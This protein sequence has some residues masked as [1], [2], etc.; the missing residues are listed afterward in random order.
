MTTARP[1]VTVLLPVYNQAQ[2]IGACI[3]SLLA[4]TYTNFELL[5]INDGSTDGTVRVCQS[6]QD[7]RIRLITN[8]E[9]K[10]I[11]YT[12]NRG[13]KVA[14]AP[15]I[16]R[17][18]ADDLATPDRLAHQHSYM[19]KHPEIGGVASWI[20]K[21]DAAGNK[22]KD[23]SA[24]LNDDPTYVTWRLM[25]DNPIAHTTMM[26]PTELV[27]EIGGYSKKALHTE[28][29]ELW[30]RIHRIRPIH[31]LPEY[32]I[33]YRVHNQSLSH[34]YRPDQ[35]L[36][37]SQIAWQ[38]V[39][40]SLGREVDSQLAQLLYYANKGYRTY[41]LPKELILDAIQLLEELYA[42]NM[43]NQPNESVQQAILIETRKL[44]KQLLFSLSWLNRQR[45]LFTNRFLRKIS[46]PAFHVSL[47]WNWRVFLKRHLGRP[48]PPP[49]P[50]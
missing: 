38:N 31:I 50:I 2:Y 32:L 13:L 15:L 24:L 18:D 7:E 40:H 34:L 27:R 12:L 46:N 4:Q 22:L 30:S 44:S 33:Y 47:F 35:E 17:M 10:G 45:L 20:I 25:Y 29:Y 43:K 19:E 49:I 14:Q 42:S 26:F 36:V 23:A 6:F 3:E 8:K 39:Q 9:N 28:D 37:A 1:G 5:I 48:L 41:Y 16:A 21:I 11:I